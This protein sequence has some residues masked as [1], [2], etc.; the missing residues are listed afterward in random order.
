[1]EEVLYLQFRGM[2]DSVFIISFLIL[3][4][5]V[6]MVFM[7]RRDNRAIRRTVFSMMLVEYVFL[8]FCSTVIC[9]DSHPELERVELMP[10]WN[11]RD[12][13]TSGKPSR[14]W[15]VILNIILYA[16]IGFLWRGLNKRFLPILFMCIGLSLVTEILQ[17]VMH[18][19]LCETD[20]V[21]HNTL[22]GVIGYFSF[23]GVIKGIKIYQ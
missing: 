1:M 21:I 9:R 22:G 8:M 14:Y 16:P 15:E 19:G 7:L 2:P 18:R 20:D 6:V 3:S 17:L 11:Y 23:V 5:M 4:I 13:L 10:F 12:V